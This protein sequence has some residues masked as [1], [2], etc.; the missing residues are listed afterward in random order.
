MTDDDRRSRQ[1]AAYRL[2][3]DRLRRTP[4]AC[5]DLDLFVAD[6][7]SAADERVLAMICAE[8][9]VRVPCKQYAEIS[10]P[11]AGYWNGYYRPRVRKDGSDD[12]R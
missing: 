8:C 12:A 6:E 3:S 2:L 9:P 5:R 4:P 10:K 11:A 7:L 1:A